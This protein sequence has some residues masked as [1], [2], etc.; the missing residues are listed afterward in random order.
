MHT[1][2]YF[3]TTVIVDLFDVSR[4][5]HTESLHVFKTIFEN[6]EIDVFINTDTMTN[7]FYIL[8]SHIKLSFDD[9]I[10]KLE[11]IKE[12][13]TIISTEEM[14]IEQTIDLCKKHIFNDYED[15]M[16][17]ICALKSECTLILTNNA[18]Y[19]K[20]AQIEVVTSKEL[21]GV[22]NAGA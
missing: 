10:E 15:G 9:A 7:L 22:F 20:N 17:Y 12:S 18:K 16:Q 2:V 6:E 5:F 13:F 11:F 1:K 4:P 8:R 3:D 14:E 21:S 19:F